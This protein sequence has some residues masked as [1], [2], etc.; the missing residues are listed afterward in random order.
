MA[1]TVAARTPVWSLADQ[2]LVSAVNF[3][4]SVILARTLGLEAFGAYAVAQMY[5]FYANT[6]QGALV[7]SPMMI[8][9]PAHGGTGGDRRRLLNGYLGYSTIVGLATVV[10][11]QLL[12]EI[13]GRWSGALSVRGLVLPLAILM[14]A[15]PTQDWL[16]R[17]HYTQSAHRRAFFSDALAYGGYLS[18]LLLLATHHRLDAAAA[19]WAM[20]FSFGA[21]ALAGLALDRYW[22]DLRRSARVIRAQWRSSRD[23]LLSWQL[24]WLAS[25]G[26]ILFGTAIA[27]QQAAGALRAAQN[28]LGPVV[29][30]FQWLDNVL[31]VHFARHLKDAGADALRLHASRLRNL[32]LV[33]LALAAV[34]LATFS[35]TLMAMIYGEPYRPFATLANAFAL[36]FLLGYAY[37]IDAYQVRVLGHTAPLAR[38]SALWAAVSV[39]S[40]LVLALSGKLDALGILAAMISGQ[41]VAVL[42]LALTRNRRPQSPHVQRHSE[43]TFIVLRD[44]RGRP[45]L[46]LPTATARHMRATLQLYAPSRWS[47]RIYRFTL[48]TLLP[49]AMTIGWVRCMS[50]AQ[51]GIPDLSPILASAPNARA[52]FVGGLISEELPGARKLT[53][54]IMDPQG[55]ALAYA[56]LG[57]HPMVLTRLAAEVE[58]LRSLVATEV[59]NKVPTVLA[60]GLLQPDGMRYLLESAGPD[61]SASAIL[62]DTHFRFLAALTTNASVLLNDVTKKLERDLAPFLSAKNLAS[63][64]VTKALAN[65]T[66]YRDSRLALCIEHGDFAPWNIR[67]R[68]DGQIFVIDWEHAQPEGLPWCDALHFCFQTAVL[69]RRRSATAVLA[70]MRA[71]MRSENARSYEQAVTSGRQTLDIDQFISLYLLRA[72][73]RSVIDGRATNPLLQRTR[74]EILG[75]LIKDR[76]KFEERTIVKV[77]SGQTVPSEECTAI[78]ATAVRGESR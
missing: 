27:G 52:D 17:V 6:F 31:P 32:G 30:L 16:R 54:R 76:Y 61:R 48:R 23:Y 19:F 39:L 58:V 59:A 44:R 25:Q 1:G 20:A 73:A 3:L 65:L 18:A 7:V 63:I 75:L 22:P 60:D 14:I 69:A 45:W 9:V 56:R 46:V 11:V 38:A 33:G 4:S 10:T 13:L 53:L 66:L 47:G 68:V 12:A 8:E 49:I 43:P 15:F 29:V 51:A 42:H 57:S 64:T 5:L 34:L 72:I 55:A 70:E 2:A 77:T 26:V 36:Y 35:G 50:A 24:Q 21:T 71:T 67:Q 74:L 62:R 40:S 78:T 28:L 41:M 37:R